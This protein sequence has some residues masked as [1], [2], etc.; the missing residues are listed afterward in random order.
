M[1]KYVF[2]TGGVTSSLGK[3]ITAAS[4]GRLLKARGLSVSILKLDPYINVD[5]GTMSPYQHGE[6]FVTDDGAETDLDL[7][8][9]ERFIDE[10]LTQL[11]NVTTGR[12]YQ[13]VIAKERRGDYLGGTVQVIPHITN[14]I[15]E[16]IGRV[17]RD[18]RADVVVVE[19]GGTVG[20]IESLPFLEA[21]RQMRKDVGRDNVLY[22]HVTL[23]PALAAT[24]ELKT[25]P[26]QHSVKELRGIGIQP[27]VIVLRS[28]HPVSH[29][30]REK[31]ALFTD[32]ATDAV[33]PAETAETIYEV[34]LR[35][36]EQGLGDLVVRELGLAERAHPADLADWRAL[37]DRIK[38]PKPQLE[39][40]LVGKYIE[41]PDAYLSVT[42]ALRHAGW[43]QERDA[44]VRWVDSEA[45]TAENVGERL[46]G[47]AGVLVPGG[48][49]HRGIEGKVLAARFAREERVPYLG[50]CLGLQCGVIEFARDVVGSQGANSTEFDVFTDAPVL[51]FMPDQRELED[52]GGTMRLG[53]YPARL[54]AG[55]KAA[56][57]YG[58]EVIY[59]RHR[60]RFEVNN[61]YR[62]ALEKGGMILSGQS[63]DGR[64]VEIVELRDHP[65][66]VASQFHPEFKSRP[67]RPHPLFSG[68]VAA[69]I[70]QAAGD[71]REPLRESVAIEA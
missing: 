57:A 22:V 62:D 43:A 33:I 36:E 58:T 59:E 19:V 71:G 49:G 13:A 46:N 9:Y 16:R 53:L 41:L 30:V 31:I 28:D 7:G 24:G 34:P 44:T 17:A 68:F 38:R 3:G 42:E 25:K 45:L 63:P 11:S 18:G 51:D 14:E 52:K 54:T 47:V 32:V 4:I 26:T 20:D 1:A 29:E 50:L 40:A 60:H 66:F 37:V 27:D 64:L 70:G 39:I 2:V 15:K 12:I 8:H 5:P 61:A 35:F 6:V 55:S 65:W 69:A 67:D 10:N 23:L 48:F 21:I 56:A